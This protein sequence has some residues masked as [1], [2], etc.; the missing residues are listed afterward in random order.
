MPTVNKEG[1][2]QPKG[3]CTFLPFLYEKSNI[4]FLEKRLHSL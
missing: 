2:D 3:F 4:F 1:A